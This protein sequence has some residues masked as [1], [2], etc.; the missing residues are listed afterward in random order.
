MV[1]T[2]QHICEE[3]M[4]TPLSPQEAEG[5]VKGPQILKVLQLHHCEHLEW[6]HHRLVWQLLKIQPQS[7]AVYGPVHHGG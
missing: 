2:H 4:T 3:G 6:L 5:F 1:Q 7:T